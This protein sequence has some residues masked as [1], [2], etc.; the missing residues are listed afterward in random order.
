MLR[1]STSASCDVA[2]VEVA[3]R[4]VT[5]TSRDEVWVTLMPGTDRNR[6]AMLDPG[7]VASFCAVISVTAAGAL[8]SDCSDRDAET[9]TCSS[10]VGGF[11]SSAGG[12]GGGCWF[13]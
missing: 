12:L 10:N 6:S 9:T 4:V 3:P 1:P 5:F 8:T 11:S 2:S 13:P 7:T